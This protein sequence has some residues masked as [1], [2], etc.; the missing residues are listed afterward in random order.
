MKSFFSNF[1][2]QSDMQT[3]FFR[4][5]ALKSLLQIGLQTCLQ[6]QHLF[7]NKLLNEEV[8]AIWLQLQLLLS[9]MRRDTRYYCYNPKYINI[10]F[11]KKTQV[12]FVYLFLSVFYNPVSA[13]FLIVLESWLK[14]TNGTAVKLGYN[15]RSVITNAF[16]CPK[17]L[18][19]HK[20]QPDYNKQ[21]QPVPSCSL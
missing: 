8:K 21:I 6:D 13:N 19:Y 7:S 5:E 11:G 4:C 17:W 20:N 9:Q 16:F 12:C 15:A 3:V 2:L 18:F 1:L 10:E 14:A